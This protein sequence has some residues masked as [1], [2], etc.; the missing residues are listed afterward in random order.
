M[1]QRGYLYSPFNSPPPATNANYVFNSNPHDLADGT[2]SHWGDA[3]GD[4]GYYIGVLAAEFKLL[5]R[6]GQTQSADSTIKELF[7]ALWA[8]N[9]MD[10]NGELLF[11]NSVL[12]HNNP[13][14]NSNPTTG[15]LN[16]F[17][18]RDDVDYDFVENNYTHF[19]YNGTKGFCSSI[20][21]NNSQDPK[22]G[23]HLQTS[24]CNAGYETNHPRGGSRYIKFKKLNLGVY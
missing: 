13:P 18:C 16:G 1:Q 4:L 10:L 15:F 12:G 14:R 9:R 23:H 2:C 24:W 11:N 3:M 17:M 21:T 6:N 19:N 7:F 20:K 8:L 22:N 5:M